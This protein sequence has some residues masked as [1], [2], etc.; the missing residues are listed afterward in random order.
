M[1]KKAEHAERVLLGEIELIGRRPEVNS[2]RIETPLPPVRPMHVK[3]TLDEVLLESG[4]QFLYSCYPTDVLRDASSNP[5]GI[6]MANRAGR[7]AVIAKTIIDATD[8]ATVARL[9]GARFRPYASGLHTFKRTVIGGEMR[10]GPQMSARLIEPAFRDHYRIIEYTIQLTMPDAGYASFTAADQQ[11]RTL[12]YHPDQQFTSDML[13]EVP[14]DAMHGQETSEGPWSSSEE[15]PLGAFRPD[16]VPRL[17]VLGGCAD[18][19]RER[20]ESLLRP[21]AL[22]D[23][24]TRLGIEAARE[25]KSLPV[26]K[27]AR[28]K[29][30]PPSAVAAPDDVQEFLAGIRP[31][32][33]WPTVS[34]DARGLPVLAEYDVVV[35]G[36]GTGGAPAGIAAARQGAKTLVLEYLSG[37]GGV[38]TQGAISNYCAGN[39]VG[40]TATIPVMEERKTSWVIEQKMEWYRSE[41][42]KAGADIW[43]RTLG[44]GA[45]VDGQDVNGVVVATPFGRGVVLAKVV[46]DTTG[47]ADI[48]AAA[49]ADCI[50]VDHNELAMQGTGLPPRNLGAGYTNTDF[51]ITDE[52]DMIDVWHMFVYAKNKYASAFDQGQL[53]DTRERRCIV[54]EHTL[55][56]LDQIN[57]RTYSDTVVQAN[58]GGYDTHG[59]TVDPYLLTTH[60]GGAGLVNI[61]YRSMLPKGLDGILV[62]SLG[63]SAHR[64]A[65]PLIRMQPDI[66][67]G[68]YAAGVAA[69]MIAEQ[70]TATR[71]IS[72]R[73]LQQHL[74]KIGNLR[75]SVLTDEDSYPIP[76]ETV[77]VAV[78]NLGDDHRRLA[79][80]FAR[81]DVA[82]PLLREAYDSA[83]G[84]KKNQYAFVLA[85]LGDG[86]GL[87]S[88]LAKVR[89]T[90]DW[91]EGW[92]Y[93]GMGQFGSAMSP[94]DK[95]IV[96][97]GRTRDT[98]A[99]PAVIEK[100]NLLTAEDSFSHHRAVALA[101][102]SIRD[103]VAAKP[104]YDLLGKPGM[105][106]H[107]HTTVEIARQRG[108]PGGT[109]AVTTRRESIREL[110]LARA[111]YRCGD[112]QGL[113]ERILRVYTKDLRGHFARHAQAVLDRGRE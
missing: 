11:A 12:T 52:T 80:V 63:L 111:L 113:G 100:L 27:D 84:E 71:H 29:G 7:Q 74:V 5:C 88:L 23:A 70:G 32:H 69:A 78:R 19:S 77:E 10:Q 41:L 51:T 44:C 39:R 92:N 31:M 46:I 91:D 1:V 21:L 72:I 89:G 87:Q 16:G 34:Q 76:D 59:Y 67:N 8:R 86:T 9:A 62:A 14:P 20:A 93:R 35:V 56:I 47:N 81:P 26:P 38:G 58:G 28:L 79:I 66:Q 60:P 25:A 43:F 73:E 36:G 65:I 48:A 6:V 3:K 82:K 55:T 97:L 45:L 22:I 99:L 94:L 104:L 24:G 40:F 61:P 2:V 17:L 33:R 75:E 106:G 37:L 13:F 68:G 95:K 107:V 103:P 98:K 102:E 4:V 50:Y 49:G 53:I 112:Y 110:S 101:T 64:D 108:A 96:A 30:N 83:E 105:T 54:G 15:L 90:S 42:L 109:N 57:R 85:M 18:I